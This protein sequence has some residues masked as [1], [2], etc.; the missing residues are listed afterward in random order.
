[1]CVVPERVIGN[2]GCLQIARGKQTRDGAAER[3]VADLQCNAAVALVIVVTPYGA[4][5]DR[6]AC[7]V[8]RLVF[9]IELFAEQGNA[10]EKRHQRQQCSDDF[11][12]SVAARLALSPHAS[13]HLNLRRS[14][15]FAR[16]GQRIPACL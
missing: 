9:H 1:M 10:D 6:I 13:R 7:R 15:R 14:A 3:S 2:T 11:D 4:F 12:D 5:P 8:E 16:S